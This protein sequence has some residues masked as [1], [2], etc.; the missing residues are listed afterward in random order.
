[1]SAA[2]DPGGALLA[3]SLS[4]R[5]HSMGNVLI[6]GVP[7]RM[8]RYPYLCELYDREAPMT[9]ILKGAQMGFTIEEILRLVGKMTSVKLRGVLYL[10][11]SDSEVQ[12]FATSRW[13]RI[14]DDNPLFMPKKGRADNAHL[15]KVGEGFI[16][17]RGAGQKGKA[18]GSTSKLKSI[19]IDELVGDERDEM[20]DE[21]WDAAEKR[22]DGSLDPHQTILSTPT[23][24]EYGV[25]LSY[26]ASDQR[27]WMWKHDACGGYTCLE[28][29]WPDCIAE[30]DDGTFDYL[31]RKCRD[32]LVRRAGQWVA[33]K[34][35][36]S[37]EHLGYHASQLCSPTKTADDIMAALLKAEGNGR[38]R[39]F[40]NQT[41]ARSY[42]EL[43]DKLTDQ[44]LNACLGTEP[45]RPRAP[46]PCFMGVDPGV[47][48]HHYVV[49]QRITDSDWEVLSWGK[50]ESRQDLHDIA[51]RFHVT[52]GVMDIGAEKHMVRDFL[53]EHRGWY[54]CQYVTGQRGT[55]L[56][57]D[58]RNQLVSVD[59][60]E[61]LDA[62]HAAITGRRVTFPRRD[63][64]YEKI[65]VPQ[66]K[67]LARMKQEDPHL[68]EVRFRWVVTGGVKN[69]HI[70]HAFNYAC[71]AAE[72]SPL[73]D[74]A[75][76]A[77][78]RE[79]GPRRRGPP[80]AMAA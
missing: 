57:W 62:S 18:H 26:Q 11:P 54:G 36:R 61:S 28:D 25:D 69:D 60:T 19:P 30:H 2:P 66:L 29:W 17:F 74:T 24:P 64:V 50:A 4:Y 45:R 72:R 41:L 52:T 8:D 56:T 68:G 39:E 79:S 55:P 32:V 31:C 47:R 37:P 3:S 27:G 65:I 22:L 9:T 6:D 67:N 46:G 70:R 73:A 10:F 14:V 58:H 1:M 76:R 20:A 42:A 23:V 34:P 78:R 5:L 13:Q 59:R 21:R 51:K 15:K 53:S 44:L 75:R 35:D 7:L 40:E 16:Y 38:M 12:D 63:E 48:Q 71:L 49:G 77:R 43:E 80:S 33:R